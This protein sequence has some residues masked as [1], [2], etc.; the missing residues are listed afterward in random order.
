MPP[1]VRDDNPSP[2]FPAACA[3]GAASGAPAADPDALRAT[4]ASLLEQVA[5]IDA[6][7]RAAGAPTPADARFRCLI[8]RLPDAVLVHRHGR[9]VYANAAAALLLGVTTPLELDGERLDALLHPDDRADAVARWERAAQLHLP[10]APATVRLRRSDGTQRSAEITDLSLLFD[11]APAVVTIAR[12]VSARV[13]GQARLLLTDRLASMGV[14]AAGVAHEINN[15]LMYMMQNAELI[16]RGLDAIALAADPLAGVPDPAAVLDRVA[17]ARECIADVRS[18]GDRVSR[19]VQRLRGFSRVDERIEPVE[20]PPVLHDAVRFAQSQIHPR[21]R[22]DVQVEALPAVSGNEGELF[23][24]FLNLLVNAA[25]AIPGGAP[26]AHRV[27]LRARADA[28]AVLVEVEDTGVGMSAAEV[29]RIFDPFYTTKAVGEGTGLGLT[30]CFSI[31]RRIGGSIAVRTEPGRGSVFSVRLPIADTAGLPV[32]EPDAAPGPLPV[33]ARSL[34]LLVVDDEAAIRTALDRALRARHTLVLCSSAR[35]AAAVLAVDDGFDLILC[36]FLMEQDTGRD[37]WEWIAT[38]RPRLLE[39]TAF[40]SGN[41][42]LPR[43][44]RFFETVPVPVL[45]KPVPVDEVERLLHA[46]GPL[47]RGV[48]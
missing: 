25:Q 48:A 28:H 38:H 8:E 41:A 27:T 42:F 2:P 23:Q 45:D 46:P 15:P 32:L 22:L 24:V 14:L 12:D 36:D 40:M 31:V 6:Q 35:E 4:R 7:L 3:D 10:E 44:R 26:D 37:L 33:R 19:L 30:I 17:E 20:L 18:G 21:A 16:Q 39:R 34:R 11:D 1:S 43:A 29:E 9:L 47:R 5:A 13:E